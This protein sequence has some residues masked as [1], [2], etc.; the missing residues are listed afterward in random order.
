MI[1][2]VNGKTNFAFSILFGPYLDSIKG[3]KWSQGMDQSEL[4]MQNLFYHSQ[5]QSFV[6]TMEKQTEF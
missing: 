3:T 1:G 2:F 4:K 6:S 5:N